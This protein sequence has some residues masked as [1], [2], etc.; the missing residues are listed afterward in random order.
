MIRPPKILCFH[1]NR[2]CYDNYGNLYVNRQRVDF[3]EH[4]NLS[5]PSLNPHGIDLNYRLCSVVEHYGTAF[6]GHYI[7]AKRIC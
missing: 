6:G 4:L 5:H 3:Q 2:L 1:L 7:A